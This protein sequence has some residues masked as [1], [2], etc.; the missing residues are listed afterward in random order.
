MHPCPGRGGRRGAAPPPAALR[1]GEWGRWPGEVLLPL[2]LPSFL[3]SPFAPL[4]C[5]PPPPPAAGRGLR[6]AG[7]GGGDAGL[8]EE[9]PPGLPCVTAAPAAPAAFPR[10]GS[11]GCRRLAAALRPPLARS[12]RPVTSRGGERPSARHPTLPATEKAPAG[13]ASNSRAAKPGS[14]VSCRRRGWSREVSR[15]R[16]GTP[17]P[18]E[19]RAGPRCCRSPHAAGSA[20]RAGAR[21]WRSPTGAELPWDYNWGLPAAPA[22]LFW[23]ETDCGRHL[24]TM[25]A[26]FA[27]FYLFGLLCLSSG[28]CGVR[29]LPAPRLPA[30]TRGRPQ[31]PVESLGG[32]VGVGA[33]GC[34]VWR[35]RPRSEVSAG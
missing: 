18:R 12:G 19:G 35:G 14:F 5:P 23:H 32:G 9:P 8:G 28:N 2:P 25:I 13:G 15:R 20:P 6:G 11:G 10:D 7:G 3:L 31:E 17:G 16:R 27:H 34:L 22:P 33:G 26:E 29:A 21:G 30:Q 24:R 4:L 1:E